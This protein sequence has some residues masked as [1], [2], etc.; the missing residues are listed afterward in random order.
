MLCCPSSTTRELARVWSIY[1]VNRSIASRT[2]LNFE[3]NCRQAVATPQQENKMVADEQIDRLSRQ[4]STQS[5]G[6]VDTILTT[7]M[8][9]L[10]L[11][12]SSL[13]AWLRQ[14]AYDQPLV[15]VL[16]SC[17]FGYLVARLGRRHAGR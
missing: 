10:N 1:L 7:T 3:Q 8:F 17:Q 4:L 11:A 2:G 5:L 13:A 16:L 12:F 15:T 9:Q 6:P 14:T